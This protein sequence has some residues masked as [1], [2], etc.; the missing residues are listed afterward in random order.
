MLLSLLWTLAGLVCV[1]LTHR[2]HDSSTMGRISCFFIPLMLPDTWGT[3]PSPLSI[4]PVKYFSLYTS[5][6]ES[7]VAAFINFL[8]PSAVSVND[9]QC[10]LSFLPLFVEVLHLDG[11]PV[12][13]N[14]HFLVVEIVHQCCPDLRFEV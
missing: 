10:N 14:V 12:V 11:H 8:T 5:A 9:S 3:P 6:S 1:L 7:P 4:L 13:R 2:A